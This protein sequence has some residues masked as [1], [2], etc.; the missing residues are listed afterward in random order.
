MVKKETIKHWT[1]AKRKYEFTLVQQLTENEGS[2][3]S[4]ACLRL[5]LHLCK[6]RKPPHKELF[7]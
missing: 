2:E 7:I 5:G 3:D 6:I 4:W 1:V